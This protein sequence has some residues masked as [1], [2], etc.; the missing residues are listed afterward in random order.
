ME[1]IM[2]WTILA[3]SISFGFSYP[4]EDQMTIPLKPGIHRTLDGDLDYND[5]EHYHSPPLVL[6]VPNNRS[7]KPVNLSTLKCPESSHLGPDTHRTLEK[8]LIFRPKSSILTKIEG[9]LCHKSRWLTRCQ[10][11]WYFSKT[12]SRKIEPIPPTFQ[13]CQEAIKLKE[14][15]ILEN[16][17]FPPPNCYWARTNDEENILIEISEHPMTYD[18]YLDGV[19]DSI[20]VGGKCSQKECETVHD[21]TIWIE[22]QRDTR[23]S[24]CDMGTEE[25]LELVSGLKQIDGNKQKYQHSVFVVGT[26]YPFMDAKGACKLRFCG[27]SGMLLSNGLWFNIAHTILPK[28]EA[29]SNFWSALPDCSSDKQVGVLGEEYEI[30]KLQ[31]T[32]ED[33]MW[34]LDCFRTVDSLAHHKKVSMLDLFR[35]AKLTPG[36]GPAYK[37]IEGTL[38]MKEVQYVKARRDTKEQANPLCAAYI[39]ESTSNQE[40]CID[41]SNYDQNGTYKGQVMNGILVTDGVLIF[42]HERFHLRQW[43]P[44]FI[45]KH[46]LQQVHHPVIGN[47]SKKLHDSIHNSL[48]KD[49]SANL[50]DVMGNWVKVAAS[51]VSGF[52]KEIEKFLIGGLLLVVILLMVGL[53]CKCKCRRKPKAKNLKANSSGDEMSPNESIF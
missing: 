37:L 5:D 19:I 28:P 49:H 50:G 6:P 10:Y 48:I 43:D 22:T 33:I 38:M 41:Y 42:P 21:S 4:I 53:L 23:P 34:D 11:T 8:W 17:G 14:E 3:L 31:A 27:K 2:F 12:I 13:E 52:F 7:W 24:Q 47:F 39:T 44:E 35:L 36:P 40:R 16:L 45:I 25:Q 46:D 51:K 20:L 32:M 15:G 18:P 26:N 30:E 9:V 29:N 1:C